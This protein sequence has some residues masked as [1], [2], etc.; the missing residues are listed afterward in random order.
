MRGNGQS[1]NLGALIIDLGRGGNSPVNTLNYDS[2]SNLNGSS[3]TSYSV[4]ASIGSAGG[5]TQRNSF[6]YL[7]EPL[8][9]VL[10]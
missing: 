10:K 9:N 7:S 6:T 2:Y 3:Y 1:Q 4:G 5:I 8:L